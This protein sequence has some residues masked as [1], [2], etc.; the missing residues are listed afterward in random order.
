VNGFFGSLG[1]FAMVA[2]FTHRQAVVRGAFLL[3]LLASAGLIA[4]AVQLPKEVEDPPG[5][6]AKKVIVEDEDPRG[7]IKKKVVVDDD[8][9]VRPKSELLPGIAPDVRLD[10]LVRAA[11][12]TSVASLKALFIKYA[13]PFD[14]VVER[15]GVLQVKPVP[16]RRPE[17]PDPVG[18]TPLDSQGRPQDI[19]STRAADIRNVEYF[20]SLVLQE[21]DSLLKQKSDAL[22]PFDRYSAAEKLLAAAL[23]FHEY[24]RDRNIRRGKGWD[25]TRTTLTERLRSVRLQFLR[26]AIAANDALRIREI[27][28]RL[29][30]AYPKDATVAQE[31]ASAQIGEAERLLRSGAHT[32]HVRAKELLDDFE[33]RFPTAGSEAARAIRAQLREIAQKAFNRAKEKK[34]VGDLQTA[35]DELARASALDPTLDGIREMQRELRSGYPILAVGVRQFPVYLSPLLARFDSEKQAV[36]LLFEGLLE[37]VPELTGAVRY[38]PGAALTLPR[39]IAGGREVLLR[40]FDRDAS[41]RPGF[42]SHDVVG[43]VKLLRTRPDTW[44][45]YPL[46]WLAPEPPAP[47]DAGLVRVPFGLAHPDPR[48][49]LTFKLLPAR[50]MADNGKAIDDTSFAERPFGTGPFRLYQSIKAEGNQPRELVFVDN[51]E[52]GRWRDRTGQPFLREIRFVD[53]SKLDPVEAFRADKLHILPDIPTGDIEKFTAPGSG[54]A[55]KVQVVTA[56]VNRRIH[57]LAVN[58]DR[59]VLQ[60]RALR[61]GISMAIDREEIL[62]DVY[63]AGKP[64]FHHAMTGPYPPNSWAAP[65]GAAAT[66]LFNRD[67]ATA[68]LKAFLATAGG[69]TEIGIAFQEDDPLARRA[70]EKI[71]A[72]LESASRDAPG[73]Q[74]LLINLDPLPLA[75]LL[76][77]VQVEH[78]RYD[79]AYV[80]FDYP[81]D[82]HPLALGAMLDPAAA[83]RG[84]RNWFKFLSHKTNPHADDHQLGQLLNSLRLYRDVAGQLVPRATEAARLFNECLPFIPLWQLDRHTVV[85]N[86]LKV[87]VDDTPLPVSPSVLNPTTLFQGVARWRI[88]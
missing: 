85:H 12:E 82:W 38:R 75:D 50:W 67:L 86:S 35:R 25:D 27:S 34:A 56:A 4:R 13:V 49:V 6:P 77:R 74:K 26:A 68:R 62:R 11:E 2:L 29:M 48:A 61:Q 32:D 36:E 81:D 33:A 20:E 52:Y 69:T 37:E 23:R 47:K 42:D 66:P 43:T 22:T 63:R 64:Q 7:T 76:N 14:R 79:L 57:M 16:V 9:V 19:R 73:G 5:K 72:Q 44:A 70:C 8:P 46:A 21:A 78:S 51:P 30:T 3:G 58:L 60:N 83:D 28:N 10:E 24:A 45:A 87:Y 84:G 80:P 31:V 1:L 55:S 88:E 39:P 54:L 17:W 59:P 53:I 40:A 15:S 18:L 65:R 71:K 41:G